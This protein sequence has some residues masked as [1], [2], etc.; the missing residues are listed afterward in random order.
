M[1]YIIPYIMSYIMS[2]IMPDIILY[3]TPDIMS[4][5]MPFH[6]PT[7]YYIT[8]KGKESAVVADLAHLQY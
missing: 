1:S 6:T 8:N 7:Q 4:Y 2:S 3:I 5:I